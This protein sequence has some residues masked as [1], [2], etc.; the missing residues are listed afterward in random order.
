MDKVSYWLDR[1]G[2]KSYITLDES[3]R[4]V[5][6]RDD[7]ILQFVRILLFLKEQDLG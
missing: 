1:I 5:E 7:A 2:A 4:H 6:T 3:Q